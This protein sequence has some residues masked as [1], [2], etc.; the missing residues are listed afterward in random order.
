MAVI[1]SGL[2]AGQA[3]RLIKAGGLYCNEHRV[4]GQT[5]R[6]EEWVQAEGAGGGEEAA[7]LFRAGKKRHALVVIER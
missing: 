1:A 6:V 5:V 2:R 3:R 7:L 4:V